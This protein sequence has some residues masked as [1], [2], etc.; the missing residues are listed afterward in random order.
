[1]A[2]SNQ[3]IQ[4]RGEKAYPRRFEWVKRIWLEWRLRPSVG[5]PLSPMVL[6][7]R[8]PNSIIVRWGDGLVIE[9]YYGFKYRQCVPIRGGFGKICA[10]GSVIVSRGYRGVLVDGQYAMWI[11]RKIEELLLPGVYSIQ[12]PEATMVGLRRIVE[13]VMKRL[14]P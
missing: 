14:L 2:Q 11:R 3:S 8:G 1:M 6:V 10:E 12:L 7:D 4:G 5:G 13:D 9:A